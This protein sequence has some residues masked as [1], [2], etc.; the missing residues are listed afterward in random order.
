MKVTRESVTSASRVMMPVYVIFFGWIG[1][2][3][4]F[5]GPDMLETPA[6]LYANDILDLRVWGV[7][8]LCVAAA[9]LAAMVGGS[10]GLLSYALLFGF[11]CCCVWT[12]VFVAAA[13]FG[14]GSNAGGA[15][16]MLAAAACFASYRSVSRREQG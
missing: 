3:Y 14:E 11:L 9:V 12:A 2:A 13:V 1:S 16:P 7:L 15:W 5:S 8:S 4:F 6:L 10:R